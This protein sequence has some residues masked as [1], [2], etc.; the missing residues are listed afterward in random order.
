MDEIDLDKFEEEFKKD[1]QK[2]LEAFLEKYPD[3]NILVMGNFGPLTLFG[4]NY[5][6]AC[7]KENINMIS[8][9]QNWEHNGNLVI[10]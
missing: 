4:G 1:F 5:C 9:Q 6:K 3:C 2:Y 10:H 7:A 8:E